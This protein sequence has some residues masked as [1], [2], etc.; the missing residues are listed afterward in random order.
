M[1]KAKQ[2]H[3]KAVPAH[4]LSVGNY[5]VYQDKIYTIQ[6]GTIILLGDKSP[7]LEK[8][9]RDIITELFVL[10][11]Y[12]EIRKEDGQFGFA[13]QKKLP[14]K[15]SQWQAT[16]DAGEVD[17]TETVNFEIIESEQTLFAKIIP[18]KTK[19]YTSSQ[20]LYILKQFNKAS[21][22]QLFESYVNKWWEK[23]QDCTSLEFSD[24]NPAN[25]V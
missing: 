16:I 19:L 10:V 11:V 23:N 1:S 8:Q 9:C 7:W 24:K 25:H 14:I 3:V 18:V 17:N 22:V 12:F 13:G 2:G 5:V 20:V 6:T 4:D 21:S 15:Y